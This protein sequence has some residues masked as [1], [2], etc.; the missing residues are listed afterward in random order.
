MSFR[1]FSSLLALCIPALALAQPVITIT[2]TVG[3]NTPT[4]LGFARCDE[5]ADTDITLYTVAVATPPIAGTLTIKL[6]SGDCSDETKCLT[7]ANAVAVAASTTI[8]LNPTE[9]IGV[10]DETNCLSAGGAGIEEKLTLFVEVV[11]TLVTP[12]VSTKKQTE[13]DDSLFIDTIKPATALDFKASGG[14]GVLNVSWLTNSAN[15]EDNDF[16]LEQEANFR[17]ECKRTGAIEEFTECGTTSG[18]TGI[19]GTFKSKIDKVNGTNLENGV[20]ID[21]QIITIDL[22]GNE[23]LPT[24]TFVGIP[25]DVLDFGENFKG[26]EQGGCAVGHGEGQ[27]LWVGF[28]IVVISLLRRNKNEA[29]I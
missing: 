22:A 5:Q 3:A 20:S 16:P 24:E 11:D 10:I 21:V 14:E 12:P 9:I 7:I 28:L 23:S 15:D 13:D 2:P 19:D 26:A 27:L 25:Q 4:T 18:S 1:I 29:Q 6:G 17:L 8:A